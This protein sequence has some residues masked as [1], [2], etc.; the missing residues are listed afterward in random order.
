MAHKSHA[1]TKNALVCFYFCLIY[2]L[3]DVINFKDRYGV[4][5]YLRVENF[6]AVCRI[7]D[8]CADV[9]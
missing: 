4:F 7:V 2:Q 3:L 1:A 8:H 5:V 9:R 6:R